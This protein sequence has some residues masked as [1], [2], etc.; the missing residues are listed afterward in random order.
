MATPEARGEHVPITGV[1][2]A[3]GTWIN[4]SKFLAA[5]YIALHFQSK[6]SGDTVTIDV[7][8]TRSDGTEA[9][10]LGR[11]DTMADALGV[12]LTCTTTGHTPTGAT[13]FDAA[14]RLSLEGC[15]A[16]FINQTA[17]PAEGTDHYRYI[18]TPL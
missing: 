17:S 6:T 2:A 18:V 11:A 5:R 14:I 16:I 7:F 9:V 10:I 3:A 15:S 13:Y 1:Q 8:G 12:S 4:L